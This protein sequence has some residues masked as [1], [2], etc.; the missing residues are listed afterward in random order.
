MYIYIY[1]YI[2]VYIYLYAFNYI[3][4]S[5]SMMLYDISMLYFPVFP[6][7]VLCCGSSVYLNGLAES[8]CRIR[9][10]AKSNSVKP[11]SLRRAEAKQVYI[12][13]VIAARMG[14]VTSYFR[15]RPRPRAFVHPHRS[16]KF[17]SIS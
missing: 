8:C 12:A 17:A 11:K 5:Y 2:Y 15:K 4:K 1:I 16:H 3:I 7:F 10:Q 14:S 6:V 13:R 9:I